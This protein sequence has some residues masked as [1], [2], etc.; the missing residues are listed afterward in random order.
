MP[1]VCCPLCL[2]TSQTD[3]LALY[4]SL[5]FYWQCVSNT[6]PST[7]VL[8]RIVWKYAL[9]EYSITDYF[10]KSHSEL[11]YPMCTSRYTHHCDRILTENLL[12]FPIAWNARAS[13]QPVRQNRTVRISA[14][15]YT[16]EDRSALRQTLCVRVTANAQ[17]ELH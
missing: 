12:C 13:V 15:I 17:R 11:V 3:V 6:S 8:R 2:E 9:H 7:F 16:N 5:F 14:L 1:S 4:F 10:P